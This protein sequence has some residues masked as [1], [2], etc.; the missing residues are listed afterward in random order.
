M[1]RKE[2]SKGVHALVGAAVTL[3]SEAM[4][5]IEWV[6]R[7]RATWGHRARATWGH[8]ARRTSGGKGGPVALAE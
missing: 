7:A 6:A 5:S 8:R 3:S 1:A 4:D 2:H